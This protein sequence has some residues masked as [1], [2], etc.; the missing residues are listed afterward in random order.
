VR[1]GV[2]LVPGPAFGVDGNFERHLRLPFS[3][4]PETLTRAVAGLA[5]AWASLGSVASSSGQSVRAVV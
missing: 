4:S 2:R 5:D 3:E 1:H